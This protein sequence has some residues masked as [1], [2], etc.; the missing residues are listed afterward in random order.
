MIG[1]KTVNSQGG[2]LYMLGGNLTVVSSI[3]SSNAA[4]I[5]EKQ[6]MVLSTIHT[7]KMN[8]QEGHYIFRREQSEHLWANIYNKH[9]I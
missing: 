3:L 8:I 9:A 1:K 2:G 7:T 4:K 6:E 5:Q